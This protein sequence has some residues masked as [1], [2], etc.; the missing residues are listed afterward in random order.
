[1]FCCG[2]GFDRV[3]KKQN[4]GQQVAGSILFVCRLRL[5][6]SFCVIFQIDI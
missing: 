5:P 1:M 6:G 2:A 4:G 3:F